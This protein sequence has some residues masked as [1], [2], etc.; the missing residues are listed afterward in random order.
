MSL[1]DVLIRRVFRRLKDALPG[2]TTA[3]RLL[4]QSGQW[5]RLPP[6]Q[7]GAAYVQFYRTRQELRSIHVEQKIAPKIVYVLFEIVFSEGGG[8]QQAKQTNEH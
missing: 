7:R 6:D 1:A 5:R 8:G 3:S 2:H 4:R